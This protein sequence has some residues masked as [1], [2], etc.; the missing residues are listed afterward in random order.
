MLDLLIYILINF[1]CGAI[2]MVW[3][4]LPKSLAAH[5]LTNAVFRKKQISLPPVSKYIDPIGLILFTFSLPGNGGMNYAIGWQKPYEHN[6][7]RLVDKERSLLQIMIVGQ[8]ATIL[9]ALFMIPL[10]KVAVTMNMSVYLQY[11]CV[12][13]I[14]FNVAI[15][16]VNLLPVPPLDMSKIIHAL[17]PN[18]YFRL[19]QN[20]HY[21]HS[22]FILLIAFG[23]LGIFASQVANALLIL[24]L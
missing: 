9:F 16:I 20:T 4:E 17:S 8:L 14:Y 7:N 13:L 19:M 18:S 6:P 1:I 11:A 21:I 3:H 22:A 10:L 12:K 15:F 2:V 24:L 23:Y 5:F